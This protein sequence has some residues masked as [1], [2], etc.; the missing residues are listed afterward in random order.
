MTTHIFRGLDAIALHLGVEAEIRDTLTRLSPDTR[1]L[2]C[3]ILDDLGFEDYDDV[4]DAWASDAYDAQ[5]PSMRANMQYR[6]WADEKVNARAG[7]A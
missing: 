3:R 1:A 2:A 7:A 5:S 4:L 6:F